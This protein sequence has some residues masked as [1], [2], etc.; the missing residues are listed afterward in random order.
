MKTGQPIQQYSIE[1]VIIYSS[2]SKCRIWPKMLKS[3]TTLVPSLI[4]FYNQFTKDFSYDL[5]YKFDPVILTHKYEK[6][7]NK[8]EEKKKSFP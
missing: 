6:V 1:H 7:M 5:S 3:S 4:G 8:I 2:L